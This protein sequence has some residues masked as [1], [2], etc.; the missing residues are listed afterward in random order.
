MMSIRPFFGDE[1]VPANAAI[2]EGALNKNVY[3]GEHMIGIGTAL[4][5]PQQIVN[6]LLN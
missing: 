3:V 2:L 4:L 5:F 6:F 1:L